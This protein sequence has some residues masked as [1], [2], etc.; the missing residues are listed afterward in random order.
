[1]PISTDQPPNLSRPADLLSS[2]CTQKKLRGSG[3]ETVPSLGISGATG[4][5]VLLQGRAIKSMTELSYAD[6]SLAFEVDDRVKLC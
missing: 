1:M 3:S 2:I 6:A 4:L 5:L